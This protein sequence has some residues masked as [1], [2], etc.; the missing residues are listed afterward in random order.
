MEIFSKKVD[1]PSTHLI[2]FA[3]PPITKA[4]ISALLIDFA[5]KPLF[6][7]VWTL[8]E[9][10][11]PVAILRAIDKR[12]FRA[13]LSKMTGVLAWNWNHHFGRLMSFSIVI[14]EERMPRIFFADD[15]AVVRSVAE[16]GQIAFAVCHGKRL[17]P[18]YKANFAAH[19]KDKDMLWNFRAQLRIEDNE[20]F[21][22][23]DD[24]LAYWLLMANSK[25]HWHKDLS[26][27]D[28]ARARWAIVYEWALRFFQEGLTHIQLCNYSDPYAT[29]DARINVPIVMPFLD[30]VARLLIRPT[31]TPQHAVQVV[32]SAL[33]D[34]KKIGD[35]VKGLLA[36][37]EKDALV[38][39][40]MECIRDTLWASLLS[41]DSSKCGL[42][43]PWLDARYE[44]GDVA[45]RY[46][47]IDFSKLGDQGLEYWKNFD[48]NSNVWFDIGYVLTGKD[49][50]ISQNTLVKELVDLKL[51]CSEHEADDA[52]HEI[53][54]E[55]REGR[56]WSVPWG[57]R[58]LINIGSLKY[59]DVYEIEGEFYGLF[60]DSNE[61]FL[62]LSV[63]IMT[64][65][66]ST[67]SI[68]M[69]DMEQKTL[70]ENSQA[71]LSLALVVAAVVR[72]F[73][74]V[75]ERYTQF[76]TKPAKNPRCST[77]QEL[78]VIYLPRVRYIKADLNSFQSHLKKDTFRA[79]HTVTG[80]MRKAEKSSS[81]Q[82][83]LAKRYGFSV[84]RGY[85]FVRPHRRGGKAAKQRQRIYRSRS[86][87]TILYKS[88]V[89]APR[90][91]RPAWF[92]FEKDVAA[93][94]ASK[95]LEVVHQAAS[96]NGDG[97]VDIYAHDEANDV[98][99]AIQ[100]KCYAPER[101][102]GPGVVR[103]LAGSLYRYP[104]GTR[105]MIVT[106]SSL[107][108]GALK[109]ASALSIE[110]I[111]GDRFAALIKEKSTEDI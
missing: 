42:R 15:S 50:P 101:K 30:E 70:K 94:V 11:L 92:D 80:H 100:C 86:A 5:D 22:F 51:D 98:V 84:P 58:V 102:I 33:N 79:A 72:D 76:A 68:L 12:N 108:F 97:G 104:D 99:W 46:I 29:E 4:E 14:P 69:A 20:H 53:L 52:I 36:A 38:E 87:S 110:V 78:S 49:L 6:Q 81:G 57:A 77:N 28:A 71:S 48:L 88:L 55:A 8:S 18:F 54:A 65:N 75:E 64:G 19:P 95:G 35:L 39:N 10:G 1:Y 93:L 61:R 82:L 3:S 37:V 85:T 106:T 73:V 83:L 90:G 2:R 16:N 59:L 9:D 107:T 63:N 74:V 21:M 26:H 66:Y 31:T 60:R 67:P 109:E 91:T 23:R 34:S 17:T 103:E 13:A 105:G 62:M 41:P 24:K 45:V 44:S 56:Q 111:D 40:L 32:C 96:R 25:M 43:R 7:G 47:D 89:K 27:R